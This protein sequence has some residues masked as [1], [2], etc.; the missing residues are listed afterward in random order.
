MRQLYAYDANESTRRLVEDGIS[1]ELTNK[2]TFR[3]FSGSVRLDYQP[4]FGTLIPRKSLF[5]EDQRPDPGDG[6]NRAYGSVFARKQCILC[7]SLRHKSYLTLLFVTLIRDSFNPR[8]GDL[9]CLGTFAHGFI[10]GC[11]LAA[12]LLR[13]AARWQLYL[14]LN[15]SNSRS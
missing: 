10:I 11:R 6:G 8:S 5:G 12:S 1:T 4:L 14:M 13:E 15:H 3:G 9:F 7:S 2:H